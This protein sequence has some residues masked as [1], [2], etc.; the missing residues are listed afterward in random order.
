MV[1]AMTAKGLNTHLVTIRNAG[2]KAVYAG[3][4]GFAMLAGAGALLIHGLKIG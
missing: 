1:M 4:I 2:M 3:L